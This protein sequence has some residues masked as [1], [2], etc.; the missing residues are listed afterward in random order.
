MCKT[1]FKVSKEEIKAYLKPEDI[2]KC[3]L[4]YRISEIKVKRCKEHLDYY[5]T[6]TIFKDKPLYK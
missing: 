5:R 1:N 6:E 3:S 2:I 4:T